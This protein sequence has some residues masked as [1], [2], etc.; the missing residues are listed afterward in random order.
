MYNYIFILNKR[1]LFVLQHVTQV[2][3]I[4]VFFPSHTTGCFTIDVI[5]TEVEISIHI[6]VLQKVA[7]ELLNA[8][9]CAQQNVKEASHTYVKENAY[10]LI[11]L[12]MANANQVIQIQFKLFILDHVPKLFRNQKSSRL[13]KMWVN[14]LKRQ[15][16]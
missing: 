14:T 8:K 11:D 1:F 16:G 6:C 12:V 15:K 2:P 3:I 7:L 4:N 13:L 9:N 5:W 10:H